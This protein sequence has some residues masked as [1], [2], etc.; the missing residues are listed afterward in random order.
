MLLTIGKTSKKYDI[1]AK[2]LRKWMKEGL[3][4][5]IRTPGGDRRVIENELRELLGLELIE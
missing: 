3:L 2:T 4:T 1:A 5:E